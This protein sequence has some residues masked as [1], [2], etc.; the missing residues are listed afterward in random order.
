MARP[1]TSSRMDR[2]TAA[3][4]HPPF[5]ESFGPFSRRWS[6]RNNRQERSQG[7]GISATASFV[8]SMPRDIGFITL[9]SS[10]L[11][12]HDGLS[13]RVIRISAKAIARITHCPP[14]IEKPPRRHE[15]RL[16]GFSGSPSFF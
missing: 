14:M 9:S 7:A 4:T 12:S 15:P 10:D 3:E 16:L 6:V 5:F 2:P 8:T 13:S 1:S 11:R